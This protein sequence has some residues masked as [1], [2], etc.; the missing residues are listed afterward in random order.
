M[1]IAATSGDTGVSCYILTSVL[2]SSA[3]TLLSC[4]SAFWM[5]DEVCQGLWRLRVCTYRHGLTQNWPAKAAL[6]QQL[7][8]P[9][10]C[11]VLLY[12][13]PLKSVFV[14]FFFLQS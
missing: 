12:M 5:V 11:V 1:V 9:P 7:K 8:P 13:L 2:S 10:S 3:L 4:R 14:P 6:G